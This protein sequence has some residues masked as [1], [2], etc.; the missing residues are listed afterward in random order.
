MGRTCHVSKDRN[1]NVCHVYARKLAHARNLCYNLLRMV[2]LSLQLLVPLLLCSIR[3]WRC[4]SLDMR[5]L[6][7]KPRR[8]RHCQ[9]TQNDQGEEHYASKWQLCCQGKVIAW[10]SSGKCPDRA[11]IESL[12]NPWE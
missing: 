9:Y 11:I 5:L 8:Q 2:W 7:W 12:Y 10:S 3:L 1:R 4:R 6:L